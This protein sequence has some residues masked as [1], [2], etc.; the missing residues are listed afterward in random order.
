MSS[1]KALM[2]AG[3]SGAEREVYSSYVNDAKNN[4]YEDVDKKYILNIYKLVLDKQVDYD[5]LY[6]KRLNI[7]NL[8]NE[9]N[10][11]IEKYSDIFEKVEKT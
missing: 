1:Y 7:E 11:M 5:K 6:E 10:E 4:Y 3:I 9:R 8:I 2:N